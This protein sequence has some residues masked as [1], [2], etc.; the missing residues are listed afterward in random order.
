MLKRTHSCG[1]LRAS[2]AG[3]AVV[4]A[5][6]V[7]AFRDH[8]QGLVFIDLRDRD[9]LTQLV[10]EKDDA[11]AD[12]VEIASKLRG[13]DVIA[14][15]GT[16]RVRAGGGNPKLATGEIEVVVHELDLIS[17][18][19]VP[20]FS[21]SDE[22][23]LPG[24]E[25][26]LK[27]RYLDLRRPKMQGFLRTRHR[28]TKIARDYFDEQGFIEVETPYLCRSTPEGARDFIVP[29]RVQPGQ[30]YAL[31]QSPQIF[32]QILMVAGAE[33]YMQICRC[34]R[35][36]DPRAD[37]QA[38][39]SQI[40]LEMSFVD[41]ED[42]I[43]TMEGFARELWQKVLGVSVP[44]MDRLTY[45]ECMDRFGIDRPDRRFGLELVDVSDLCTKTDF[46]V[47]TEALAKRRGV[48]KAIR[49]PGGASKLTR[50][51][52]DGYSEF[53]K[54]FGAGGVPTTKVAMVDGKLALEAGIAKFVQPIADELIQRLGCEA[55]DQ[56][57]F[58]ADTYAI[59]TKAL[60]ELRL[61]VARDLDLIDENAWDFLW[62][63]D[64]PMFEHDEE[65][66]RYYSL[67]HPFTAPNP[68][69]VEAF[70]AADAQDVDAIEGIVS[71]GYDLVCNGSEVGGGSIRIH[72]RDVQSR[73]FNLLGMSDTEA[74]D[75]FSF[76]LEALRFGAPP[77]GGIA[78]GLDRLVMQLTG[79]D[80]IR[81]VIAFPKTLNGGDLMSDAPNSVSD[82][83]L[84]ELQVRSTAA[85]RGSDASSTTPA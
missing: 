18:S 28:I 47:F 20:P 19:D 55:G 58:G 49:V 8:G 29:S 73:V 43:T 59:C 81:D 35:D 77:H 79:T 64:F 33:R 63:I 10:F 69:Q 57:L 75:K 15:R 11:S 21:P 56:L 13:E 67:H 38:E 54:Q 16:V 17:K 27:H 41:R 44:P 65:T 53:A 4:L 23:N 46:K 7:H 82:E 84:A 3:R 51:V 68:D 78:F 30:W 36:E 85:K 9:G 24:E 45:R 14:A 71:A 32:K 74:K 40:D 31:P 66:N 76:L 2:D 83:Q 61:K 5:G 48:V 34:F 72:R 22:E 37:R 6:W 1:Q 80:N 62:V 25:L 42:V 12:L 39:F 52:T 50:K 26:R 70:L 60:G